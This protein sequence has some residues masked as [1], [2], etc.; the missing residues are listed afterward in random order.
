MQPPKGS[1]PP[2]YACTQQD[3]APGIPL[4]GMLCSQNRRRAALRAW[5]AFGAVADSSRAGVINKQSQTKTLRGAAKRCEL[6]RGQRGTAPNAAELLNKWVVCRQMC[7]WD[8]RT[9]GVF[10]P[11]PLPMEPRCVGAVVKAVAQRVTHGWPRGQTL[12]AP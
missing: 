8:G 1:D 12:P 7:P 9:R 3:F 2:P 11:R 10:A 6:A 4:E 5:D